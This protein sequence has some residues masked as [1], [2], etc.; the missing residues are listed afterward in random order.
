MTDLET[1]VVDRDGPVLTVTLSRPERKNAL[2]PQMAAELLELFRG[3][4]QDGEVRVV[5]I[6]GAGDAFCSGADLGA[7]A[8]T[9]HALVRMRDIHR[10]AQAL[11]DVPQ[12]TIARINGVAA[13]AGLNIALGC[14]L[15]VAST[16]ARFSEI[17]ARRGLSTDFGGAWLLPRLV[18]LHRAKE[19]ALLA[20]IL[21]ASEAERLGLVN[22]VVPPDELDAVVDEWAR[23]LAAG[24]PIALAQTK[25]MLNQS[26]ESSWETMLA[27]EGTAQAVNFSTADTVEAMSAFFE[28]REPTFEGR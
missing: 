2:D 17:F 13:G 26:V 25:Q 3:V 27:A 10:V 18:G 8:D 24:P 11:H 5:V 23:R 22:R 6:T 12:P 16:E 15:T 28:K 14:D 21:P 9:A 4:P 7:T 20:E 19:L 1:L